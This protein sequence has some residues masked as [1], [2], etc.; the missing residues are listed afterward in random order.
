MI[1]ENDEHRICLV[2]SPALPTTS[3]E[4]GEYGTGTDDG[5]I[6]A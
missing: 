1:S 6:D 2:R 5:Q 4:Q 3:G